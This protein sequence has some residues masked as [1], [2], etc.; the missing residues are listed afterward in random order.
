MARVARV[1]EDSGEL[2]DVGVD[3]DGCGE[4][5][6]AGVVESLAGSRCSLACGDDRAEAVELAGCPVVAW[7]EVLAP[8]V[9]GVLVGVADCLGRVLE[10]ELVV[11]AL[12][13]EYFRER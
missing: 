6:L 7:A 3:R 10:H 8:G 2:D 12:S 9:V 13:A 4:S 5:A 11:T 1:E